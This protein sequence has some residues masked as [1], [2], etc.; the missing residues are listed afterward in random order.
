MCNPSWAKL[1][2]GVTLEPNWSFTW[3]GILQETNS[4]T[5]QFWQ[6]LIQRNKVYSEKKSLFRETEVFKPVW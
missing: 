1:E 6:K 5:N 3:F 4:V 2:V